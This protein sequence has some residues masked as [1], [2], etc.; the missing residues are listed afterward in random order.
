VNR[1]SSESQPKL[2]FDIGLHVGDDSACYLSRGY[3]VVA[4]EANR[5][6]V[7]EAKQRF[8]T[9]IAAG[10]LTLV[11]AAI[12]HTS[13][14]QISFY[15]NDT[16]LGKSSIHLGHDHRD[17]KLREV[18]V[19]TVSLA[20]LFQT[21][22]TPW[23]LKIDIEGADEMAVESLP[24]GCPLPEYL[25]CELEHG[26]PI[27]DLL[28]SYGY[29]DFKLINGGT[30]TGS[31][32]IFN[33]EFFLRALRKT[34]VLCSPVQSLIAGFPKAI[35]PK[36]TQWDPPRPRLPFQRSMQTSG[37]FGE[38]ADGRWLSEAEMKRHLAKLYRQCAQSNLLHAFWF[39]L[40]ARH[41]TARPAIR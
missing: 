7:E 15:V 2:V 26:S 12:W 1:I 23:Y 41:K 32:P 21:Y 22:G 27:V 30:L 39:D 25:S 29:V 20:D 37:P 19:Q 8:P 28:S 5:E 11:N 9:E 14:A 34:S 36:K 35:R 4:V 31:T 10:Q 6:L 16:Y 17:G 24:R 13:N 33:D 18:K 40:H 38:E 3:R